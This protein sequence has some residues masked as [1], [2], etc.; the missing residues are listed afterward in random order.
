MAFRVAGSKMNTMAG[1]KMT[2]MAGS[3]WLE[4]PVSYVKQKVEPE[5]GSV[6]GKSNLKTWY[7]ICT[8]AKALSVLYSPSHKSGVC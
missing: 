4:Y 5:C 3:E 2:T 1:S 6:V 7:S 8:Q